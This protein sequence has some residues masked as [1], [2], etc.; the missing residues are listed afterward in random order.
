MSDTLRQAVPSGGSIAGS[1][2]YL[3]EAGQGQGPCWDLPLACGSSEQNRPSPTGRPP[4]QLPHA[5]LK[6]LAVGCCFFPEGGL[7]SL[8]PAHSTSRLERKELR[9]DSLSGPLPLG[10]GGDLGGPHSHAKAEPNAHVCSCPLHLRRARVSQSLSGSSL[11]T[12]AAQPV[13]Q[14]ADQT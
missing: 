12:P 4:W 14:G 5:G 13:Y 2:E 11:A 9:H 1:Q 10:L 8:L 6:S 7:H 3:G